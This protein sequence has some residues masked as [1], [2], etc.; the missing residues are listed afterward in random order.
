MGIPVLNKDAVSVVTVGSDTSVKFIIAT[1]TGRERIALID[2]LRNADTLR[3]QYEACLQ[4]F[5]VAVTDIHGLKTAQG[6]PVQPR[7]I[8]TPRGA[9]VDPEWANE[10]L[11]S[12]IIFKVIDLAAEANVI[13]GEEEKNSQERS[14]SATT[15]PA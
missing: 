9:R 14:G 13:S 5:G 10:S 7:K 12:A 2:A 15:S 3:D 6:V 8:D 4:A 1:L 11:P